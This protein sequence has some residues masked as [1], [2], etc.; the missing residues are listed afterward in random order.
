MNYQ[1]LYN[2][3]YS[4]LKTNYQPNMA[5][6]YNSAPKYNQIAS[7]DK[8]NYPVEDI[9][10]VP[11]N[12][13]IYI[14]MSDEI[15]QHHKYDERECDDMV[16]TSPSESTS[17]MPVKRHFTTEEAIGIAKALG[18]D[19][20]KLGFDIE[21]FRMGLDVEL[22]HGRRTPRTNVTSDD[23]ILTGKIALAHLLEFPN[24]YTRLKKLESDAQK[25]WAMQQN[26]TYNQR[27]SNWI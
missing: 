11:Y 20:D 4:E 25:Y 13:I 16:K 10:P 8:Y 9:F 12:N 24:Y 17:N 15:R 18:I 14:I 19:F 21:Q 7:Y 27:A 26:K 22:E 1:Q 23:P 6:L 5:H 2:Q 3:P